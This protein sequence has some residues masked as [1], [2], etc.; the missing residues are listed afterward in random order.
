MCI[1]NRNYLFVGCE[2]NT[3]KLLEIKEGSII[4]NLNS[5]TRHVLAIKKFNHPKY[6]KCLISQGQLRDQIRLWN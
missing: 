3:I 5:H 4:K 6:G 2:D 1:W